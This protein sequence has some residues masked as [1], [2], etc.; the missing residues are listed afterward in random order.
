VDRLHNIAIPNIYGIYEECKL[1]TLHNF[2]CKPELE[3]ILLRET[4]TKDLSP[5]LG[6]TAHK[7][8]TEQKGTISVTRD[9]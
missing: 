8:G 9:I 7:T 5:T 1:R 2:L 4:E 6:N 3:E